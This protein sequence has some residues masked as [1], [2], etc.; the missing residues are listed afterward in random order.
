[1]QGHRV[2]T[3]TNTG[4]GERS[5]LLTKDVNVSTHITD[6]VNTFK[7]E[8]ISDA[9]LVGHSYGGLVIS[10]VANRIPGKLRS[11][12]FLDAFLPDDG[13]ALITKSAFRESLLEMTA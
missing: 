2:L 7:W 12:V 11:I 6:I 10:G 1:M 5:H 13:D 3:P 9:V 8:D 4:L